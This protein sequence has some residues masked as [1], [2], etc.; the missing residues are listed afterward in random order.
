MMLDDHYNL[1]IGN[2]NRCQPHGPT[3]I[4]YDD[5]SMIYGHFENNQPK[6]MLVYEGENI[7]V[8]GHEALLVVEE[9]SSK[10]LLLIQAQ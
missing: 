10:L 2:W 5:S 6:T 4:I 3:L 8:Y 1:I 7:I 9:P